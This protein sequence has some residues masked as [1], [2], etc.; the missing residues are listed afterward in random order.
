MLLCLFRAD[1]SNW[2]LLFCKNVFFSLDFDCLSSVSSDLILVLGYAIAPDMRFF[3]RIRSTRSQKIHSCQF[4]RLHT[5]KESQSLRAQLRKDD[6]WFGNDF[7]F[8]LGKKP[9]VH[10]KIFLDDIRVVFL[11]NLARLRTS[12]LLLKNPPCSEWLTVHITSLLRGSM[13]LPSREF[14]SLHLLPA[15]LRFSRCLIS[16]SLVCLK[17]DKGMNCHPTMRKRPSNFCEQSITISNK[18]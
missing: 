6:V 13:F 4:H 5:S 11:P 3:D 15:Q 8:T 2:S 18:Q 12:G 1:I 17:G 10:C 7:I 16:L 14:E 9:Y